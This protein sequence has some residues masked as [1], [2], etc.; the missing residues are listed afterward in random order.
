[1]KGPRPQQSL[2]S[3]VSFGEGF[4]HRE[5]YR[6]AS[7]NPALS[8]LR[9]EAAEQHDERVCREVC[10]LARGYTTA[11]TNYRVEESV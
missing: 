1:M 8:A 6:G 7:N 2:A 10:V 4:I 5:T 11:A 3:S 9:K